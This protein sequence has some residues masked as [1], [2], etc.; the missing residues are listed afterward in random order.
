MIRRPLSVVRFPDA[1]VER[2][3][4]AVAD[5]G[6]LEADHIG[7][8]FG[9]AQPQRHL[10]AE[11]AA[12][13]VVIAAAN[14]LAGDHQGEARA[15]AL[16]PPQKADERGMRLALRHAVQIDARVDRLRAALEPRLEAPV[17]RRKR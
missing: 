14:A 6:G 15:V 17:E 13:A 8:E 3:L 16:R 4:P 2:A 1:Q 12:L 7:T 10:A 11:H 5:M 9:E